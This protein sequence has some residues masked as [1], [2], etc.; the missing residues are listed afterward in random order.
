MQAPQFDVF[1][2]VLISQP[3]VLLPSQLANVPTHEVISHVPVLHEVF[4]LAYAHVTPHPPQLLFVRR[5]VSQPL[6]YKPSQSANPVLHE[7]IV[8]LPLVQLGVPFA[9]KHAMPHPPQLFTSFVI[10]VSHPFIEFPSQS[11]R[12]PA[13]IDTPHVLLLQAGVPP[14]GG[15]L[16]MHMPQL[17]TLFV[18]LIS[19]PLATFMSQ[20]A[21]PTLH[22]IEH[23][24]LMHDGVPLFVLQPAPQLPQL[25]ALVF[26]FVS[27]PFAAIPSQSPNPALH[28]AI[29]QPPFEH[30]GV[31]LANMQT[32]P[33]APQLFTFVLMFVSQPSVAT[34]LQSANGGAQASTLQLP[35]THLVD[36]FGSEQAL[37][38]VPQFCGSVWVLISHPSLSTL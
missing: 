21:K 19:Q 33:Q 38:H 20:L 30:A 13:H 4:A 1:V 23:M 11:P 6:A 29:V 24:P 26:R 3:F 16:F 27:H 12:P 25:V 31:A 5:L 37:S 10:V 32:V 22:A 36:E 28:M 34:R 35:M 2:A 18:V 17:F 9:T 7:R 14:A 15:Q 8:Q